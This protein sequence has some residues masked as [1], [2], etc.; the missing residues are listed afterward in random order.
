MRMWAFSVCVLCFSRGAFGQTCEYPIAD[1]RTCAKRS[2]RVPHTPR[3]NGCGP[4]GLPVSFPQGYLS[5]DYVPAC[6]AHDVCYETCNSDKAQCDAQFRTSLE[7]VCLQAYPLPQGDLDDQRDRRGVCLARAYAYANAV[8]NFGQKAYDAA[9]KVACECCSMPAPT[10]YAGTLNYNY[11][12]GGPSTGS[13]RVELTGASTVTL[14]RMADGSYELAGR[15][16]LS[17]GLEELASCDCVLR[18]GS[19]PLTGRLLLVSATKTYAWTMTAAFEVPATCSP[20]N[21]TSSCPWTSRLVQ[22]NYNS[23]DEACPGAGTTTF[24]APERLMGASN[25][26][27][28]LA[29]GTVSSAST[30]SWSFASQ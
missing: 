6:N 8:K 14:V 11:S 22:V 19:G 13:R 17:A 29:D 23:G 25:R 12:A 16:D 24:E 1:L 5:A 10:G 15:F 4:E 2:P 18:A 26:T 9:Q 3:T 28:R 7:D 20:R 21:G 27:C 30:A